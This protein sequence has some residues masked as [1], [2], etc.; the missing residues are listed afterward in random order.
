MQSAFRKALIPTLVGLAA[1]ARAAIDFTPTVNQYQ[2]EGALYSSATFKDEK[3]S[4]SIIMPRSWTCHGDSSRLQMAPPQQTL[5]EGVLQSVPTK[6][7]LRFDAATVTSLEQQVLTT[8]PPESRSATIVSQQENPVILNQN[9]SYEFVV[10]YQAL[11]QTFLRSVILVSCPDQ[12]L[13]FKFTAPK[14]TFDALNRSFRQSLCSWQ[15]IEP[16]ASSVRAVTAS[17]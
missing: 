15:W 8:L 6:T 13:I 4:V 1:T 9:L 2:S 3:R 12:A 5:A 17:R 14:T 7:P 16:A 10:S 11:G